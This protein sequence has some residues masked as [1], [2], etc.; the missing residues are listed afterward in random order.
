MRDGAA[1]PPESRFPMPG[2]GG[3]AAPENL[4]PAVSAIPWRGAHAPAE[5]VDGG[6][7]PPTVRGAYTVLLPR[8]DTDGN[9]AVGLRLPAGGTRTAR[10]GLPAWRRRR[11]AGLHCAPARRVSRL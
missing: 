9:A 10:R 6:T 8:A 1:P 5:L 4:S 7:M 3:L 2:D 11:W